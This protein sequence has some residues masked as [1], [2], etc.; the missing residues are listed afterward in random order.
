MKPRRPF[1]WSYS[2]LN[3]FETCPKRYAEV[4]VFRRVKEEPNAAA[5]WGQRAHEIVAAHL[6]G[7]AELP[8]VLEVFK[9]VIDKIKAID[10]YRLFLVEQK[11]AFDRQM[12]MLDD[13]F[14]P[15]TWFR[16]VVDVAVVAEN[17]RDVLIV[18][19]KGLALDTLLP[20]P[21]GWTTMKEVQVGDELYDID[22][23][24]CRVVG[25]S[26]VR[27]KTC[28]R[29]T[30]DD[31]TEVVC[32]EDHKWVLLNGEV[33]ETYNLQK[34]DKL[35]LASPLRCRKTKLLLHPYVLGVWLADGKTNG[36]EVFNPDDEIWEKIEACGF[37][38]SH[39]YY[40]YKNFRTHTVFG[41][42]TYLRKL[43]VLGKKHI[44]PAYLRASKAQRLE[45][46]RG[47][48]D[49]DGYANH[50]RNMAEFET[51]NYMLAKDV[52]ELVV[53]LGHR[54]VLVSISKRFN[55]KPVQSW[56][57][58][59]RPQALNPFSLS[60]K[61]DNVNAFPCGGRTYRIVRKIERI[62]TVPTQCIAVDSPTHTYLCTESMLPT[63]N[64]GK[65]KE[66]FTQLKLFAKMLFSAYPDLQRARCGFVWS[67]TGKSTHEVYTRSQI[68]VWWEE[69]LL[70]RVRRMELAYNEGRFDPRPSGLCGKWCPVPKS[71]CLY[72]R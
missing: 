36:G 54:A 47:L 12:R 5:T 15:C 27:Y 56:R 71:R 10:N 70:P 14:H 45:L 60:R 53:S 28:Y 42:R 57:V 58:C 6:R 33:V 13:F 37:A 7:Q 69:E 43:G 59:F 18:D 34:G 25:K 4:K 26:R 16:G 17:W 67:K 44:P 68:D 21:T 19:W 62:P 9:P 61:A 39:N 41:L 29:I 46:L 11:M 49:G 22:G 24:V 66:D 48:M 32:D 23:R 35:P 8:E 31:K 72:G 64:T 63:H 52:Y 2:A 38:L 3:D 1:A 51:T 50:V 20:T 55:G 30:F 65:P 40:D